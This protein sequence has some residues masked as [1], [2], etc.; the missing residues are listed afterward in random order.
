MS[1]APYHRL[2]TE[3]LTLEPLVAAHAA[4]IAA[5]YL[6]ERLW[7]YFPRLRPEDAGAVH[8][9]FERWSAGPPGD[10]AGV[11]AWE[12]WVGFLH[13]TRIA[14]G[15]FQATI[16]RDEPAAIAYLVFPD[17]Q[18]R[19]FALEAMRPIVAHLHRDHGTQR[20]V[21]EMDVR[22]AASIATAQR[23]GLREVARTQVDDDRTGA[24]GIELRYEGPAHPA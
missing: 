23:L 3:R 2:A 13:G 5:A 21:A 20:I 15:T 14:V 17:F 12:N 18:R 8:A 9:R 11:E 4:E 6:D 10:V 16:E 7:T 1:G 24:R 22:N 19:G